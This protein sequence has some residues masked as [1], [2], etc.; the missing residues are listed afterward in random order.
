KGFARLG[1]ATNLTMLHGGLVA[2]APEAEGLHVLQ[3]AFAAAVGD[4]ADVVRVPQRVAEPD[5]ERLADLAVGFRAALAAEH[6]TQE[7]EALFEVFALEP[8]D[9]AAPRV[10]LPDAAP[11]ERGVGLEFPPIDA[12]VAAERAAS[13]R[14]FLPA[15]AAEAAPA[16]SAGQ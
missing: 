4:R 8:A 16:G 15:L 12:G 11:E 7:G 6:V 1:S 9:R 2:M 13:R 10:A 3:T 5:L 14:H